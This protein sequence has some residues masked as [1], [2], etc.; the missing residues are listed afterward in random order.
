MASQNLQD[1]VQIQRL[2]P[3]ALREAL[4]SPRLLRCH[5]AHTTMQLPGSFLRLFGADVPLPVRRP[6]WNTTGKHHPPHESEVGGDPIY[7][8]FPDH[9]SPPLKLIIS[10]FLTPLHLKYSLAL[11]PQ[12]FRTR[13]YTHRYLP[14]PI[15][16][17]LRIWFCVPDAYNTWYI[18]HVQ[19]LLNMSQ[20]THKD[21]H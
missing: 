5:I 15:L 17:S 11:A 13:T 19:F 20:K 7:E 3:D 9:Y 16:E 12:S 14:L 1:E 21:I 18:N 8:T 2:A 4:S 10:S 6:L